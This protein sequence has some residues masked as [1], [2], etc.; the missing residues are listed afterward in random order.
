[1]ALHRVFTL[2]AKQEVL[3]FTNDAKQEV[4][5]LLSV[6]FLASPIL[7]MFSFIFIYFLIY[8]LYF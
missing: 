5:D 6:F 7:K 8:Y 1:M 3:F 4:D 2:H